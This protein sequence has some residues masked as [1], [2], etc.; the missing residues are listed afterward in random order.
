MNPVI[1]QLYARKSVRAYEDRPVPEE[2]KRAVLEAAFQAPTAGNQMLYTV[3]D[4]QD[5]KIKARLADLCD[6]QPFIARAPVALIFLADCRR[7]LDA[8]RLAGCAPRRPGPGD[9]LLA[10]ADAAIAAQNAVVAA[11]SLGLGS[12]YIGDVLE[13]CAQMRDLLGLPKEVVPAAMLVM[14]YPTPQQAAR[15]KPPRFD[16]RYIVR[17][18]RYAPLSE[19]EQRAM[20]RSRE[21]AAGRPDV[22]Y[23][24]QIRAFCHRKYESAFSREMSRSAAEYLK[25]FLDGEW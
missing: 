25:P 14:G 15:K 23:E 1:D 2:V 6:H 7:W 21:A 12:C 16:G 17:E 11:H 8:Y 20:Y 3:I 4:V 24:A 22:D 19:A 10:V 13:N 5:E 9:L 18:N